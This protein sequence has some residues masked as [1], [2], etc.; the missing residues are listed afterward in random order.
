MPPRPA[1]AKTRWDQK[2]VYKALPA[3]EIDSC[4]VWMA[5]TFFQ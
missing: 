3:F 1:G 2:E 4:Q 5:E